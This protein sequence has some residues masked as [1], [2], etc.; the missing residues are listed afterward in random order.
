MIV[1][2]YGED[3]FSVLDK[4]FASEVQFAQCVSADL[5]MGA[6]I[7]VQFN[8]RFHCKR[9]ATEQ[10]SKWGAPPQV[11]TAFLVNKRVWCL[12]TKR[13][14]WDKPTYS[15]FKRSISAMANMI[16]YYDLGSDYLALHE[17]GCGLDKLDWEHVE[18]IWKPYLNKRFKRI[19]IYHPKKTLL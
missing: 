17:L 15:D 2:H 10:Y 1:Q 18:A 12:V 8:K 6:G 3:V 4:P 5:T 11:G 13:N 19:D 7:A 9:I 16:S 14:Y